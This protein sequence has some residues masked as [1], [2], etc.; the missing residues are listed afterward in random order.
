[1]NVFFATFIVS[2][3][4]II[5][6]PGEQFRV[7]FSG[8]KAASPNVW[9]NSHRKGCTPFTSKARKKTPNW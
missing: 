4:L 9:A 5:T 7:G 1:M 2:E 8:K 6:K 3:I